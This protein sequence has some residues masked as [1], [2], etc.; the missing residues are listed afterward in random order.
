MKK[1]IPQIF[2]VLLG[3]PHLIFTS[4]NNGARDLIEDWPMTILGFLVA[5]GLG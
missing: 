2:T 5:I 3:S 1:Y 4:I